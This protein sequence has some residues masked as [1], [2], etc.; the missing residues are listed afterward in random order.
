MAV[1]HFLP[2]AIAHFE[3]ADLI[4]ALTTGI[5]MLDSDLCVVYANVA[6]Q[7]LLAA[8]VNQARGK[9][10]L[11]L[12]LEAESLGALMRRAVDTGETLS[13][14]ELSVQAGPLGR[15]HRV[16]DVTMT[17]LDSEFDRKYLLLEIADATQ[18]QRITR[19]NE[20]IS[21]LDSSR[22]MVRQLAHEIKNPLGGLR[23]AAQLLERE[24]P[25]EELKEYTRVIIGEADRLRALV[26]SLLGPGR[27]VR[28]E[29]A[30]VHE[31]IDRVY[32]LARAEAPAGVSIERDYDP[33][34]PS[35]ALD[36]DLLVQ[37]MLNLARN[38]VQALGER[39]RLTLRSRA[40]TNATIGTERH[41]VVASLQ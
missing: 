14:R 1:E 18:R 5:V 26:D 33:S 39:G 37:A 10:F 11:S 41:R 15:E 35:L 25:T 40:L 36:R 38:A 2:S 16:I 23:G 8:S 34:L 24:L 32:R 30:N 29:L 12:V 22:Q 13:E 19:E 3:P 21:R 6:A 9:P 17:P 4:G 20:L 27:P 28:R 7:D 31:L